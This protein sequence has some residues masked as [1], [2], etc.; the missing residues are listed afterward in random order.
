MD[1]N[2]FIKVRLAASQKMS[3]QEPFSHETGNNCSSILLGTSRQSAHGRVASF[4]VQT[5]LIA[6]CSILV[7][8]ACTKPRAKAWAYSC[9][10]GYTFTI[11]YSNPDNAGDIAIFEDASGTTKLPRAVSASGAKYSNGATIFWSKG[12]EA[13]VTVADDV[14]HKGCRVT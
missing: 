2:A 1:S 14:Q 10:D 3:A 4:G 7:L 13:M 6:L 9:P 5:A 11:T 12:E 8:T